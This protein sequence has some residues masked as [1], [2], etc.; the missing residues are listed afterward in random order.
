MSLNM[1]ILCCIIVL[2][3]IINRIPLHHMMSCECIVIRGT[4]PWLLIIWVAYDVYN[5]KNAAMNI[6]V[7]HE[8]FSS[9][10]VFYP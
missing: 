2:C 6:F 4:I 10:P 9:S 1:A 8:I 3:H 5:L 7:Y